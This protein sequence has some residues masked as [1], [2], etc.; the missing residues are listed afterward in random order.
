LPSNTTTDAPPIIR[1]FDLL[2]VVGNEKGT[3]TEW[4]APDAAALIAAA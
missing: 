1:P 4:P 3:V 2:M